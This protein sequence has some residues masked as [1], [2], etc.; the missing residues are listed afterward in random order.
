M[1]TKHDFHPNKKLT[2][3]CGLFCPACTLFIGTA[4][5][6]PNACSQCGTINS[7][8]DLKCR[9]CDTEPSCAYVDRHKDEILSYL[10][11]K[12]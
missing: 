3:V 10:S 1:T 11:K 12:Q 6:D 8:Y 5:N 9:A 2:A 4:Q 7:A